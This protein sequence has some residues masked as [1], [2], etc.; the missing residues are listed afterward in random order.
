MPSTDVITQ[1][2]DG[3]LTVSNHDGVLTVVGAEK[4]TLVSVFTLNGVEMGAAVV[5]GCTATL[6]HHIPTGNVAVVKIGGKIM[7]IMIN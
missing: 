4:G 6:T 5:K 3:M 1:V 2:A 7:K